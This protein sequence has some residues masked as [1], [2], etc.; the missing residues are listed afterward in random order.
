M[1]K[2]DCSKCFKAQSIHCQRCPH[3]LSFREGLDLF[4]SK[5]E[6]EKKK[7]KKKS[8]STGFSNIQ[9]PYN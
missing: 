9:N 8:S 5:I 2:Q 6:E 1:K 7:D 3:P 4:F